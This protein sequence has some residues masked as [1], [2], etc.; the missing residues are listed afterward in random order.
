MTGSA[1]TATGKNALQSNTSGIN[2]TASGL[3][4]LQVNT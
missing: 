3:N 2:N 1:S 4:A